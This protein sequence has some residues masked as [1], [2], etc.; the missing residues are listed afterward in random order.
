MKALKEA[1]LKESVVVNGNA[2]QLNTFLNHRVDVDLVTRMG[3]EIHSAF[4]DEEVDAIL[5]IEASGIATA[6]TTAQAFGNIPLI[7]AKKGHSLTEDPD[8]FSAQVFSVSSREVNT[9]HIIRSIL[10]EG[11]RVLIVDDFLGEGEAVEG[12]ISIARQARCDVAGVA[13]CVEKAFAA[14]GRRL[15]AEGIRVVSLATIE[16]VQDGKIVLGED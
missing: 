2:V 3:R 1:I 6:F 9:I 16:S 5:A 14:G 8:M 11:M 10:P 15:R 12:L 4:R 13:V 7:Y